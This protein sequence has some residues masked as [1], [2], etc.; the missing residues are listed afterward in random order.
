MLAQMT[1]TLVRMNSNCRYTKEGRL[2]PVIKWLGDEWV[3]YL[4]GEGWGASLGDTPKEAYDDWKR[5]C[6]DGY[7]GG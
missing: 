2:K 5:Y 3:C 4:I 6:T 1:G 7:K